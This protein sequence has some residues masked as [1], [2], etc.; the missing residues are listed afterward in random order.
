MARPLN[1]QVIV[2]T[3]A[4]SGI[5]RETALRLARRG[6]TLVLAA[7]NEGALREVAAQIAAEGGTAQVV[8]TDVADRDQVE[9]LAERAMERFG[10]IDT[11]INDAGVSVYATVA[12]ATL[13][14]IERVIQVNLLGPIYG[15]KAALARMRPR[16]EGTL[17]NVGSGISE[18]AVPLQAPYAA[19]KHGLKGFT[20]ALRMELEHAKSGISVTLIMP[21]SINTPFFDHARAKLDG[22][23][24]RPI[25]PVYEPAAVAE[26]IVAAVESP[27]RDIYVGLPAKL[28]ALG[29]ALSPSL[30]D[31][32]MLQYGSMFKLQ[33]ADRADDHRDNLFEPSAAPLTA[34]A[35]WT[36]LTQPTSLYTRFMESRPNQQRLLAGAAIVGGLLWL[37]RSAQA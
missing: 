1:E 5:G 3:G 4:S 9:Q 35:E 21:A 36:T 29:D 7:R 28:L 37:R 31:W 13:D 12:D 18:R 30:L 34:R 8:V 33:M 16:G 26:A 27:R 15:C 32:L 19:S 2:L 14:E 11:W 25:P 24:P 10:R 23:A 17:I 20:D 22:R 6:A